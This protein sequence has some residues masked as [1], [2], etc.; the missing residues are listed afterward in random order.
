MQLVFN[1]NYL[2]GEDN[3]LFC[4]ELG[5]A[6]VTSSGVDAI[7]HYI[8]SAPC[9]YSKLSAVQK[10]FNQ[11]LKCSVHGLAFDDGVIDYKHFSTIMK[12]LCSR[13][14]ALYAYQQEDC[15]FLERAS[16]MSF[17]SLSQNL[18]APRPATIAVQGLSCLSPCHRIF[19]TFRCALTD[20]HVLA[21]WL[22]SEQTRLQ[23]ELLC[24]PPSTNGCDP[25]KPNMCG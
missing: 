13:A 3:E 21:Q 5:V 20:A 25:A 6:L 1:C 2:K 24:S 22:Y 4:K 19:R 17:T 10:D 8:F 9:A 14:T 18:K 16:G 23:S 12:N 11:K 15:E 7:E